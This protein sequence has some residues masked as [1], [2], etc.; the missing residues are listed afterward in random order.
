VIGVEALSQ[1]AAFA[2]GAWRPEPVALDVAG[3]L[4][5]EPADGVD[6]AD[7]RGHFALK[8]AL[9]VAAA[10]GHNLLMTGP[11]GSGK[12]MLARRMPTILPPLTLEE[13]LETTR[14]HSVAGL[15]GSGP[16][17]TR[18]P[19][20]APHH[21]I[22][23]PGLVGGGST[24]SPGEA[25]LAQHGVLFLDELAEFRR[26]ALE[27][28]RQPLEDGYISITR[29]QRAVRFPARFMLLAAS[30]PCPCGYSGDDRRPCRCPA[31]ALQRYDGR[32]SGPLV[33]RIDL[34]LRVEQPTRSEL[35]TGTTQSSGEVRERVTAAR[36]RQAAR[37]TGGNGR[38]NADMTPA[39]VRLLCRLEGSAQ[40]T[41]ERA[42]GAVGLTARG[43]HR[44]LRVARTIADLD[45]REQISAADVAQAVSYRQ[46]PFAGSTLETRSA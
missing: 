34:M 42:H 27:A 23:G 33:D 46:L 19:F 6:L 16:L 2:T 36:R 25:S 43:H 37:L 45:G 44:V 38:C 4:A 20:R 39:E 10:G 40:T 41:F 14:I 7:V 26:P 5:E 29:G 24:P 28:L 32:L 35:S 8:R 3:L 9:E 18:R 11:P 13:A 30:N 31:G 22:S 15:L 12:S 1:L 17:V 21:S